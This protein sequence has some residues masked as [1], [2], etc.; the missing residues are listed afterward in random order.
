MMISIRHTGIAESFIGERNFKSKHILREDRHIWEIK[1][2]PDFLL[3]CKFI[4]KSSLLKDET[5]QFLKTT[6]AFCA[7]NKFPLLKD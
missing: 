6:H 5:D 4:D 2:S 1:N 7:F 3:I